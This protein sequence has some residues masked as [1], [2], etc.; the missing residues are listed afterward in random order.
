[1]KLFSRADFKVKV[2][3][4]LMRIPFQ[5]SVYTVYTP[6]ILTIEFFEIKTT[7]TY[8]HYEVMRVKLTLIHI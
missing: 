5:L 3:N 6:F 1:M 2:R 8:T 7:T 4:M